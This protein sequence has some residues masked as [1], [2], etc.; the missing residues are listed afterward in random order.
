MECQLLEAS[1][2]LLYLM[3]IN[4]FLYVTL[5]LSNETLQVV[6]P[7]INKVYIH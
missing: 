1:D 3:V 6:F 2:F 5:L 4:T 7:I